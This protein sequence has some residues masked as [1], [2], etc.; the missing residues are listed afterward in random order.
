MAIAVLV[1]LIALRGSP[2]L[3]RRATCSVFNDTAILVMLA[4]GQMAVILTR[5]IDL[6]IAANL[7]LCGMIAA[8]LNSVAPGVPSWR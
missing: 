6:S 5:C 7:A 2:A 3:R 4:L 1:V 8:M